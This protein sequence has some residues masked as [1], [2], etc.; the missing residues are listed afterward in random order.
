MRSRIH[1]GNL[2]GLAW[3]LRVI[4]EQHLDRVTVFEPSS[5]GMRSNPRAGDHGIST[6][7]S[8]VVLDPLLTAFR[9]AIGSSCCFECLL[10][11]TNH[12]RRR[13][14]EHA[15]GYAGSHDAEVRVPAAVD[16]TP[17]GPVPGGASSLGLG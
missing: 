5:Y 8:W 7:D 16:H 15:M 6:E 11:W 1:I 14:L 3:Q 9:I 12:D 13:Q 4:V 17:D 2:E 10:V